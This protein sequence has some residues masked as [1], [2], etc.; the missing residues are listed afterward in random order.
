MPW[1]RFWYSFLLIKSTKTHRLSLSSFTNAWRFCFWQRLTQTNCLVLVCRRFNKI[2]ISICMTIDQ[3]TACLRPL[4]GVVDLHVQV[5]ATGFFQCHFYD[6]IVYVNAWS[7]RT[8]R[9]HI[10]TMKPGDLCSFVLVMCPHML[11]LH[12][13]S[14][15]ERNCTFVVLMR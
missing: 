2:R 12:Y 7:G 9:M 3:M 10:S 8:Q 15:A 14:Q 11:S 5:L 4:G 13:H 1:P 6:S